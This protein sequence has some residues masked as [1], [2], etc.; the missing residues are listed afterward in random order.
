MNF[1]LSSSEL[2]I[3]ISCRFSVTVTIMMRERER[4]R[5]RERLGENDFGKRK[6]DKKFY[7]RRGLFLGQNTILYLNFLFA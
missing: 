1:A 7:I 5:E 3:T 6:R 2:A 4:E